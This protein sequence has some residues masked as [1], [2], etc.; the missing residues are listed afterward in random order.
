MNDRIK[1][2]SPKHLQMVEFVVTHPGAPTEELAAFFHLDYDYTRALVAGVMFKEEV[3]KRQEEIRLDLQDRYVKTL[4]KAYDLT[5]AALVAD[6]VTIENPNIEAILKDKAIDRAYSLGHAK[7]AE[8]SMAFSAHAMVPVEMLG[9]LAAVADQLG[10]PVQK[11]HRLE[12]P[13]GED[14][15]EAEVGG[16][17]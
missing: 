9:K 3:K 13:S 2:L 11:R 5:D 16:A 4:A 1:K 8:K 17:G 14:I 7:V 15:I 6:K 12:R 10:K